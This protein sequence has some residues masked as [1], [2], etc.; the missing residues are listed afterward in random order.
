[1]DACGF[2]LGNRPNGAL[3]NSQHGLC[4]LLLELV[5]GVEDRAQIELAAI[6]QLEGRVVARD[7]AV[8]VA[9]ALTPVLVV[10]ATDA[11]LQHDLPDALL[12]IRRRE[13]LA[14]AGYQH[15][16]HALRIGAK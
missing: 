4:A 11:W 7:H 3:G 6:R 13:P 16:P 1:M 9:A 10:S 2:V 14:A 8:K 15:L 12:A 5:L